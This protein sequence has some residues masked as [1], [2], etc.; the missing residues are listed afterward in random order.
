LVDVSI[1]EKR[2]EA[3]TLRVPL[4]TA[5]RLNDSRKNTGLKKAGFLI[6]LRMHPHEPGMSALTK[7][8]D[9]IRMTRL[10]GPEKE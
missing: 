9:I 2:A 8:G 3:A 1:A 4:G 10:D 5:S 7:G 6:F